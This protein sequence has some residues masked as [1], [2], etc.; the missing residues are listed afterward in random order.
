MST[1]YVP[2]SAFG[3]WFLQTKTWVNRVLDVALE[4][5]QELMPEKK[6]TYET[7]VDVGCGYGHSLKK[8]SE[9][10]SPSLLIGLD[11]DMDMINAS[12]AY[13]LKENLHAK[14]IHCSSNN[15]PLASNS[16]DLIFCHQTF[17]H[18]IEQQKAISEFFRILK[19]GGY[20]L[21]A[22][23][24]KYYIHSW[25]IRLLFRHPMHVQKTA[26]EYLELLRNAGFNIN[27]NAISYPYLW[28]SRKDF[29]IMERLFKI[30]PP[31]NKKETLI[32]LVAIKPSLTSK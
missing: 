26:E 11:V 28:W 8:L 13:S 30:T 18:I 10:F 15:V 32:N 14:L 12:K 21:F 25:I 23:S 31:Q 19:P 20:L 1:I 7:V 24:T 3:K 6:Q 9:Q 29:A 16:V 4:D 5:L 27:Q 22:E 2:E 17:H